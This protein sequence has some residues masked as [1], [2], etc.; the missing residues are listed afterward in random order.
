M[1]LPLLAI[2]L[3]SA[4]AG[5]L[6]N[7]FAN[8]SA[9]DRAEELQKM[10]LDQWIKI[11]I[12]DPEDQKIALEQLVQ[13][14]T[15]S[16]ALEAAIEAKPS[17]FE[18]I[19]VSPNLKSAQQRALSQLEQIGSG[20]L[21]L[22]D[23]VALQDA[24]QASQIKDRGNRQAIQADMARRG[25]TGSGFE[26]ASRLQNQQGLSDQNANNSLK[27]ASLAQNRALDA[28]M[29]AGNLATK[30]RDQDSGEQERRAQAVDKINLFNTQNLQDIQRRNLA[31]QNAAQIA[32]LAEK[33]R[34]ADQNTQTRN[35]QQK[36]NQEL[37]QQQF[38]NQAR[39]AAG[40]SGQYGNLANTAQRGGQITG[41]LFSTLGGGV[42]N[43]ANTLANQE[44]WAD[45]FNKQ[46][47]PTTPQAPTT[48]AATVADAMEDLERKKKLGITGVWA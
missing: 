8:K 10:G 42:S 11:N 36:Y 30:Y 23:K 17:E 34:I 40:M 26:L 47:T 33:Q 13:M 27:I 20:G 46:A 39:K 25:L 29:N 15:V 7:Y 45:Y 22:E 6:G 41:N 32:N 3:G 5:G 9:N 31:A 12:P 43:V 37:Y 44:F 38:E 1:A 16:P 2:G 21:R 28:I 14:G 18:K 24:M 4:L 35:Q 48:P 19:S